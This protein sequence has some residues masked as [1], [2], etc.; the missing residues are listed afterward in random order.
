MTDRRS[1]TGSGFDAWFYLAKTI[2]ETVPEFW[3]KLQ[4]FLYDKLK[5][6]RVLSEQAGIESIKVA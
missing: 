3:N 2:K 6:E 1:S 4:P 5:L